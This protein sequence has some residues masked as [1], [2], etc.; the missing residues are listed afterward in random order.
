MALNEFEMDL[1]VEI[2]YSSHG[3]QLVL[4][5]SSQLQVIF[6]RL[7]TYCANSTLTGHF[8]DITGYTS[9][10]P[11]LGM[12]VNVQAYFP[13]WE[14]ELMCKLISQPGN[15]LMC[16]LISHPGNKY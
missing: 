12:G 5:T 1:E 8:R 7:G 15:E 2:E 16:K 11:I 6:S 14:W 3:P 13:S 4:P 10:F 9:L